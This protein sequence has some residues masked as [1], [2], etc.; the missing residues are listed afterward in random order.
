[1]ARGK[2]ARVTVILECTN[3]VRGGVNN[4]KESKGISRYVT[5]KNRHNTPGRLELKKILSLLLQTDNSW[6]DKEIDRIKC[7]SFFTR[8][9]KGDTPYS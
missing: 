4:N 7:L 1:M 8:K 5:Q 2:D 6:G 3:C 9:M